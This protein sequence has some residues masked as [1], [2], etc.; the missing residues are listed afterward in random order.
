MLRIGLTGGIG[1]GKS[2]AAARLGALG[3]LVVDADRIAREVVEP[4]T[5]GFESVVAEFGRGVV[6][7]DGSLDRAALGRLVFGDEARRKALN[8]IVHPLVYR[9]RAE[10][11]AAAAADAI[12]VED[13]PLL[14][15]NR[16][17]GGFHLVI[18][19]HAPAGERVR[20]LVDS[21][22]MASDD[23]WARVRSQ[24]SDDERRAAADIWLDNTGKVGELD[25]AVDTLWE[26]RLVPFEQNVRTRTA[27]RRPTPPT[28]VPYDPDWPAQAARLADRVAY[29]MG[30][31]ATRVDHVGSTAVPGLRA[32]DVIDLQ[33]TVRSLEDADAAR[34]T[35][36]DAGFIHRPV[37]AD[38]PKPTDPDPDR[39]RKRLHVSA[40]P[41]R[42]VNLHIRAAGTAG[43]R[44]ALV[45]RDWLRAVPAEADAY[46]AEKR[47]LAGVHSTTDEYAE[48]K[49]PWFDAAL[50]RAE[51]WAT[52]TGWSPPPLSRS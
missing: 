10:L 32:K 22:G 2:T 34:E 47:R 24:A 51:E 20:R 3:A 18:V 52:R 41:G 5:P 46:E 23:V 50:A 45:F 9:R 11:V 8:A 17:G 26:D 12:V 42:A 37:T 7:G 16:L 44:Y 39:W 27:G 30:E 4:G 6:T 31:L 15:E 28:L 36:E 49:E 29:A 13:I 25:A 43:W 33:A 35:L 14:V 48:A 19:V 38:Y 1:S 40:D 21:R